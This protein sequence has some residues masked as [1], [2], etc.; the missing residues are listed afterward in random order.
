M[1]IA[2]SVWE[3]LLQSRSEQPSSKSQELAEER[4]HAIRRS[5]NGRTSKRLPGARVVRASRSP[6]PLPSP[7]G[8]G[9]IRR[10]T[11]NYSLL[12]PDEE[13]S[14][15]PAAPGAAIAV[16][17][18]CK[19]GGGVAVR[20]NSVPIRFHIRSISVPYPLHVGY[21]S[22]THPGPARPL[23]GSFGGVPGVAAPGPGSWF[24]GD[25]FAGR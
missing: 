18:T 15:V 19:R 22:V 14:A 9:R 11:S 7:S 24:P 20:C 3:V 8:R 13:R 23:A 5:G 2:T 17:G 1:T 6:S 10:R 12:T 16:I 4:L 25:C 21:T